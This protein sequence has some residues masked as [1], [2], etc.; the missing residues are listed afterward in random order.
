MRRL[1]RPISHEES[2][3]LV[4]H[5]DELRTRILI[6][7]AGLAIAFSFCLWQADAVFEVVNRP[8]EDAQQRSEGAGPD[9]IRQQLA[10]DR[11]LSAALEQTAPGL[12]AI[13][14]TL[15][16]LAVQGELDA[17]TRRAIRTSS[18]RLAAAA[19]AIERAAGATP[20]SGERRPVTL[21]V[22]EPFMTTLTVAAYAAILLIL[23]LI[24]YQAYAF[25]LPAFNP[26]ERSV[27][28]PLMMTVPG[29]FLAGV[30]FSYFV[31]LPGAVGFL[32][33]FGSEN[34]DILIQ[35]R[36]YYQFAVMMMG[37]IGLLFQIPVG[38]LVVTRLG[39][40]SSAQMRQNRP[41]FILGAAVLAA[42]GNG[43]PDPFTMI[44]VLIPL[45]LLFE[46]SVRL[47]GW[48][49]RRDRALEAERT[50]GSAGGEPG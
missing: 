14:R 2:L 38:V 1:N 15:R 4:E 44:F 40:V 28:M 19:Q 9:P 17:R 34:F 5:L 13:D 3:T 8:L 47:A 33:N 42:I 10:F 25:I 32:Q 27:A 48:L 45:V 43:S 26:R 31:V 36:A 22:A 6:C 11:E 46:L 20:R 49:E 35:A 39:I 50:D 29:L 41:Y 23:P 12:L 30:V 37:G 21:G 24:L 18:R 7:L 16:Q